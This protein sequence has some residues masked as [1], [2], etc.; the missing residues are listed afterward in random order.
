V[1]AVRSK[2]GRKGRLGTWGR[3]ARGA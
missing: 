1:L 2:Q 3:Q